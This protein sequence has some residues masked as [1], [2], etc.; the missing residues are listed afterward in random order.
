MSLLIAALLW[1]PAVS[2]DSKGPKTIGNS[3]PTD[4]DQRPPGLALYGITLVCLLTLI[5]CH[6]G[7]LSK[8]L[9]RWYDFSKRPRHMF[10]RGSVNAHPDAQ[11][12]TSEV[13]LSL[14][15]L[16]QCINKITWAWFGIYEYFKWKFKRLKHTIH[17]AQPIHLLVFEMYIRPLG[18]VL[19]S[20]S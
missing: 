20:L 8:V 2:A 7:M 12:S 10:L 17:K 11:Y 18:A 14:A 4:A 5:A 3:Y 6:L 19:Q 16:L 9:E 13:L 1:K 15:Y